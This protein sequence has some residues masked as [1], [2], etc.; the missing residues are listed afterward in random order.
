L[1]AGLQCKKRLWF[2][3]HEPAGDDS[4][5]SPQPIFARGKR[6]GAAAREF[7]GDGVFIDLPYFEVEERV[8]AT[9]AAMVA[10]AP[11]IYEASFLADGVFVSVDALER[12]R[13]GYRLIEVKGSLDVKP[14]HIVDAS[15]QLHV[16]ERAGIDVKRVEVMHLNRECRH[17]DLSNLFVRSDVTPL[18]REIAL[19]VQKSVKECAAAL[20][21]PL[22]TIAVGDHCSSPYPCAFMDRCWPRFPQHH[23]SDLF[24]IRKKKL[25]TLI[26]SGVERIHDLPADFAAKGVVRRQIDSVRS[27]R[28]H[29]EPTL[30][31]SLQR[32]QGPVAY[33]DFETVQ[34]E[35]PSWPGCGPLMQVPVQMSCH[36]D[37]PGGL[38][39]HAWLAEDASDPRERLAQALIDACAGAKTIL[40][41]YAGFE[42][43]RIAELI[44]L[45]PKFAPK[46]Q[47][48]HDRIVDLLP[49][50][51]D[52]VYHPD[53]NGSFSLKSVLPA[54]VPDLG[55]DDL[56]IAEGGSASEL[57]QSLLFDTE[58][59]AAVRANLRSQLLAYC[60]RDTLAMVR[61]HERL[62]ALAEGNE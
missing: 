41:Y 26:Q 8:A 35:V 18:A 40:S 9:Q 21:G 58:M 4:E 6:I 13:N 44:A 34:L 57:L 1:V 43:A 17:P 19:T 61:V 23:V 3:V 5:T 16:L 55:Y 28:L 20:R 10:K 56:E 27:G 52:N 22:P 46:L 12:R 51:R 45:L 7:L 62:K 24:G 37:G 60:E 59:E 49:I 29:V 25:Q 31:A 53:F 39:H 30:R 47:R 36:V 42:R 38:E 33:L 48:I 11:Y 32:I 2:H 54:L 15:I 50:V 14:E